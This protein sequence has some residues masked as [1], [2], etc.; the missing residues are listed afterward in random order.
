[1]P[2]AKALERELRNLIRRSQSQGA[3]L[4]TLVH[5]D[6]D[7]SVYPLL[8]YIE[9][10]PGSQASDLTRNFHVG[11]ATISRQLQ[12]LEDLGLIERDL[13]FGDKRR[14]TIELTSDGRE[15][16][17]AAA[18]ARVKL[19]REVLR[20]WTD[21]DIHMLAELLGRY[22]RDFTRWRATKDLTPAD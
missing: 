7:A 12:R 11:R 1:M 9:A 10:H 16:L 3:L 4:A 19:L 14:R 15:R 21:T 22:S 6:L 17:E 5:P 20:D 2:A 18:E 8:A 13:D